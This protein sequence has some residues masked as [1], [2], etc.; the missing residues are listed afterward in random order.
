MLFSQIGGVLFCQSGGS[1]FGGFLYFAKMEGSF[2]A[3]PEGSQFGWVLF[4][5]IRKGHILPIWRGH[6]SEGS[7]FCQ[8][9]RVTFNYSRGVPIRSVLYF[10]S[11]ERSQFGE[12][13]F[14]P[15]RKGR[16]L[17]IWRDPVF[18]QSGGV[19]VRMGPDLPNR[20]GSDSED[21]YF[22]KLEWS[23]LPIW[24]VPILRVPIFCQFG[25]VLFCQSGGVPIPRD[26]K[27]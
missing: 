9:G 16:L 8:S 25:V 14:L 20:R 6:N 18:C 13:P 11:P 1:Q 24:R 4:L 5:P 21:S 22:A 3:N 26:P 17:P 7:R 27:F 19:P 15:I 10:D 12:V 2:F 23:F